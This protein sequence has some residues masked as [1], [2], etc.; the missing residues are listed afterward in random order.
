MSAISQ[1]ESKAE[2]LVKDRVIAISK[3]GSRD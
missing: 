1:R 3:G 2:K